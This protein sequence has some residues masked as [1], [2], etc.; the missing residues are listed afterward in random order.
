LAQTFIV[1][2]IEVWICRHQIHTAMNELKNNCE[3]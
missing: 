1:K 3:I 2:P